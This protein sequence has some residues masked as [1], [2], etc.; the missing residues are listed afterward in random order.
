[1]ER[2]KHRSKIII[3]AA[4]FLSLRVTV[5]SQVAQQAERVSSSP[6]KALQSVFASSASATESKCGTGLILWSIQ[7]RNQLSPQQR[8]DVE[9][10]LIRLTLD[11]NRT[12]P[13]NRFRIHY[14]TSGTDSPALLDAAGFRISGTHEAYIDSVMAVFDYCWQKEVDSLGYEQ[15]PE[16]QGLGGGSEYDIYIIDFA[17][18]TFGYTD[19]NNEILLSP[20]NSPNERYT[21]HI[22]IENDF[23]GYRTPGMDGL[24]VT[25]AHEFHHA[26]QIGSYGIWTSSPNQD[27]FFNELTSS[28]MEDVV[29]DEINDYHEDVKMY[30]R[31]FTDALKR[32]LPFTYYPLNPFTDGRLGYERSVWAHFLARRFG[33]DIMRL[34]WTQTKVQPVVQSM[35]M[36]LEPLGTSLES[37]YALFSYWNYFTGDRADTVRFYPEGKFYPR[38]KPN[39]TTNFTGSTAVFANGAFPLSTQLYEVSLGLDTMTTFVVNT[40]VEAVI[41]QDNALRNYELRVTSG[42]VTTPH[43]VLNNG[44]KV[45]IIVD[46]LDRWRTLYLSSST[47]G[48]I[49][50]LQPEAS[51]NPLRLSDA[52]NLALPVNEPAS[53][54]ADVFVFS[55]SLDLVFSGQFQ[56]SESFGN[57]LVNVPS[58]LLHSKVASG[59]YF[60]VAKVAENEYRWKVAIIQ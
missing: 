22:V 32:S 1:M 3:G 46:Q 7:Q 35:R 42:I 59:V 44:L 20:P 58:T 33:S 39:G 25:A 2:A 14:D 19:F 13:S 56:V 6:L 23:Q 11:K 12:S 21:T 37:E 50:R 16:D 8:S 17:G 18:G 26:I 27:F 43:H 55:S 36:I 53:S 30:F 9:K 52:P 51:P 45:S 28:W 40:D 57:R 38:F 49:V 34:I 5:Q 24:K 41:R 54:P 60:I 10:A 31:D 4:V 47:K 15:P 48:D 29:F